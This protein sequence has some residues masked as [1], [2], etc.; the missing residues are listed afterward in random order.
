MWEKREGD[1]RGEK[2][3]GREGLGEEEEE[4][5]YKVSK[6][7]ERGR[8][9]EKRGGIR[10]EEPLGSRGVNILMVFSSRKMCV[11][12]CVCVAGPCGA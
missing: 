8:E 12:V 10:G 6:G 9:Q 11:C 7:E 1:R 5:E 3:M 2:K 4:R